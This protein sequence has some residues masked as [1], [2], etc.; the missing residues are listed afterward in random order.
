[1]AIY[2]IV[3]HILKLPSLWLRRRGLQAAA[4]DKCENWEDKPEYGRMREGRGDR[5]K[6]KEYVVKRAGRYCQL[7]MRT[8]T[9]GWEDIARTAEGLDTVQWIGGNCQ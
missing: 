5:K 7:G 4:G 6:G 1:M 9:G 8:L 3:N 2:G